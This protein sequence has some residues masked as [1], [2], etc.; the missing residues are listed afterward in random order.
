VVWLAVVATGAVVWLTV[1]VTGAVV[2]LAVVA[3]GAVVWLTVVVT[4]AVLLLAVVVTAGVVWL[5]VVVTGAVVW[6]AV[7]VTG[8]VVWLAVVVADPVVVVVVVGLAVVAAVVEDG[9]AV[10]VGVVGAFAEVVEEVAGVVAVATA[11]ATVATGAELVCWA[12]GCPEVV[13]TEVPRAV[14]TLAADAAAT[15]KVQNR[16]T[17]ISSAR[18]RTRPTDERSR[19]SVIVLVGS[20][21]CCDLPH[22]VPLGLVPLPEPSPGDANPKRQTAQN[23]STVRPLTRFRRL[24]ARLI[25]YRP[26]SAQQPTLR[27]THLWPA[28]HHRRNL[29]SPT[30]AV[31][32]RSPLA[33]VSSCARSGW[34]IARSSHTALS[35]GVTKAAKLPGPLT[36]GM[37]GTSLPPFVFPAF[38][39]RAGSR[40]QRM[41]GAP[42][43]DPD[44]EEAKPRWTLRERT[45]D[46]E[47]SLQ[48]FALS[49]RALMA[50]TCLHLRITMGRP[51]SPLRAHAILLVG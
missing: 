21:G 4:G 36:F 24:P 15:P 42:V 23:L 31:A 17:Q 30:A 40:P 25:K 5:A 50:G 37:V 8:A 6:L 35:G 18:S 3:T 16:A 9:V 22:Q 45:G 27:L 46:R 51:P 43:S 41:G 39:S 12:E 26:V 13:G 19:R 38:S 49:R 7:V 1:V 47:N 32:E 14:D 48:P 2:W 10:V 29:A 28:T 44:D 34:D 33:I 11:S 20:P